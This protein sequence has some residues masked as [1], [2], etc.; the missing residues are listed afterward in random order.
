MEP[1]IH[2][3]YLV[4]TVTKIKNFTIVCILPADAF[5]IIFVFANKTCA[6]INIQYTSELV[7]V[8]EHFK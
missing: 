2:I 1:H 6:K 7:M 4:D 5:H 3:P 8:E